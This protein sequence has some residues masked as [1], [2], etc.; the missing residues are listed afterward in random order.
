MTCNDC[1]DPETMALRITRPAF[2][3][4][5]DRS[6]GSTSPRPPARRCARTSAASA[7]SSTTSS[8]DNKILTFPWEKGLNID[9]IND[10]YDE[11]GFK[12]W[13]HKDTGAPMFKIQHPEF[14]LYSSSVHNQSGVSCA[15]CHMP[16]IREGAL[17]VTTTGSAAP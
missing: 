9:N 11:Y 1:H 10:Y 14:E 3:N 2:T 12:D 6:A 8:G 5:M 7:T 13:E 4:A 15:D 16:Y 17:K